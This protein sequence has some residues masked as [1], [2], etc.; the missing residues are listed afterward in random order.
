MRARLSGPQDE[1]RA[2]VTLVSACLLIFV[3]QWPRAARAAHLDPSVPLEARL[4]GALM[5]TMFLLPLL[6][7]A[8]AAGSHLI[9]RAL[10][11]QGSYFRAR[12]ALFWSLL[13]VTPLMLF[14]GLLAGFAGAGPGLT[15]VGLLTLGA[16]VTIW[17]ACLREAELEPSARSA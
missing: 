2:L 1:G 8:L 9:A 10:G 13:A 11:G 3:A 17:G 4:A 6:L 7:Y 12:M 5:A 16:F 14:Q 15:A